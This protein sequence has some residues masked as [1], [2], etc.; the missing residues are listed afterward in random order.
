MQTRWQI[1]GSSAY[2][3]Q[4]EREPETDPI[5]PTTSIRSALICIKAPTVAVCYDLRD[6]R[7][8]DL[9]SGTD[10]GRDAFTGYAC[11]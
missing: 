6:E 3:H 4:D 5:V 7:Y 9:P 11:R 2:G 10:V 1:A 8:H